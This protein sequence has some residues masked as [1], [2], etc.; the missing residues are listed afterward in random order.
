MGCSVHKTSPAHHHG[1][2]DAAS[3]NEVHGGE[4]EREKERCVGQVNGL[5]LDEH[6]MDTT[7]LTTRGRKMNVFDARAD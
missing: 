6:P 5:R 2:S 1:R 3:V 7:M 4:R